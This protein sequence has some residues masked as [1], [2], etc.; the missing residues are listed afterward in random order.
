MDNAI[1]YKIR[2]NYFIEV[3]SE[4]LD[5]LSIQEEEYFRDEDRIYF[6]VKDFN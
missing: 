6:L 4:I 2:D 3:G 5:Q 1:L